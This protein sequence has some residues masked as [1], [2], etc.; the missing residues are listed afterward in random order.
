[1]A[2]RMGRRQVI[3]SRSSGLAASYCFGLSTL[4]GRVGF[5][6]DQP[7][8]GHPERVWKSGL[9]SGRRRSICYVVCLDKLEKQRLKS[10][11]RSIGCGVSPDFRV[12][13][14]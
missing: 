1:M 8:A 11:V 7:H 6:E 2:S 12:T 10:L 5:S 14:Q 4:F 13:R 3:G 9:L